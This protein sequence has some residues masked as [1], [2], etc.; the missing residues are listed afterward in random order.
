V[1]RQSL[2]PCS[3]RPSPPRSLTYDWAQHQADGGPFKQT[4]LATVLAPV[5]HSACMS[6]WVSTCMSE[7]DFDFL[8]CCFGRPISYADILVGSLISA[9]PVRW[10]EIKVNVV[11]DSFCGD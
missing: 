8:A 10:R 9:P 3:S 6:T 2:E 1:Q 11:A 5:D 4:A 7:T